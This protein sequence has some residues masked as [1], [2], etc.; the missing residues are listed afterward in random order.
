MYIVKQLDYSYFSPFSAKVGS[1]PAS[2]VDRTVDYPLHH[3]AY[4]TALGNK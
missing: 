1:E 3:A 4:C 2:S